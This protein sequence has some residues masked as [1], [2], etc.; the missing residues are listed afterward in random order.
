MRLKEE[1]RGVMSEN[2]YFIISMVVSGS[3]FMRLSMKNGWAINIW[4][5]ISTKTRHSLNVIVW[6]TTYVVLLI[7]L[8]VILELFSFESTIIKFILGGVSGIYFATT[9]RLVIKSK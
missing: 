4:E 5:K 8:Q 6:L 2:I 9:S 7:I 1:R 3:I